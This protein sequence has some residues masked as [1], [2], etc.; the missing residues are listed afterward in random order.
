MRM[1]KEEI[2][3]KIHFPIWGPFLFSWKKEKQLSEVLISSLDI[4]V[5]C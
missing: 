5:S 2:F 4:L 1:E 3:F